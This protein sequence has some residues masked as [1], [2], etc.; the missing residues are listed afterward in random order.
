MVRTI[1]AGVI[2]SI[3]CSSVHGMPKTPIAIRSVSSQCYS[4]FI[5][6]LGI[7]GISCGGWLSPSVLL[8]TTVASFFG[9]RWRVRRRM[10]GLESNAVFRKEILIV[11]QAIEQLSLRKSTASL[12]GDCR[13]GYTL[14]TSL[15][16]VGTRIFSI[17]LDLSLRAQHAR[18][19]A[20][21]LACSS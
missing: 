7:L 14:C 11:A 10:Q 2:I 9:S 19:Y 15:G 13:S 8:I 1:V 16:A 17:A 6:G 21:R 20:L 5:L 4:F 12:P 3:V 18:K